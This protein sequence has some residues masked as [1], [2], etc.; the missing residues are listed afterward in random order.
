M[1][2]PSTIKSSFFVAVLAGILAFPFTGFG[3]IEY[4]PSQT[5][6]AEG[7][8]AS[9]LG[10]SNIPVRTHDSLGNINIVHQ[11]DL[12]LNLSSDMDQKFYNVLPEEYVAGNYE[13]IVVVPNDVKEQGLTAGLVKSE[14]TYDLIVK[15][16]GDEL[17]YHTVDL[18]LLVISK[19]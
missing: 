18:S 17:E 16:S 9:V 3:L 7:Q 6:T 5:A 10:V 19:L 8:M 1:K 11:E 2:I 4:S 13:I 14:L 12:T 15:L